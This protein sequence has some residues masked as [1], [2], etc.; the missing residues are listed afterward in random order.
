MLGS[1]CKSNE[2]SRTFDCFGASLSGLA[3]PTDGY[4]REAN[5]SAAIL[6]RTVMDGVDLQASAFQSSTMDS[7]SLV[8]ANLI[9]G[10]FQ[11]TNLRNANLTN[12]DLRFANLH[13]A[14]L[15]NTSLSRIQWMRTTCPDGRTV[16]A[17][18]PGRVAAISTAS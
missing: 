5:L 15:T 6:T 3:M 8:G 10:L 12:T 11:T 1:G 4:L 13:L 14:D 9:M 17:L 2:A 16:T 7:A 18:P